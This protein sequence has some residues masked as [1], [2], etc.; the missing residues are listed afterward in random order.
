MTAAANE[1]ETK[2]SL[3]SL[4]NSVLE[5]YSIYDS[6][7]QM[8]QTTFVKVEHLIK[9]PNGAM[10]NDSTELILERTQ[11]SDGFIENRE[12]VRRSS[13]ISYEIDNVEHVLSSTQKLSTKH[14]DQDSFQSNLNDSRTKFNDF[15]T[16]YDLSKLDSDQKFQS[17]EDI[18]QLHQETISSNIKNDDDIPPLLKSYVE[19]SSQDYENFQKEVD[20]EE[21]EILDSESDLNIP[22]ERILEESLESSKTLEQ[23]K[24]E[25]LD[26]SY[27]EITPELRVSQPEV[28]KP[29][30]KT[31]V[32][33]DQPEFVPPLQN[34]RLNFEEGTYE[35]ASLGQKMKIEDSIVSKQ[36][37][38]KLKLDKESYLLS[39]I[40]EPETGLITLPNVPKPLSFKEL[41]ECPFENSDLEIFYPESR[42]TVPIKNVPTTPV[43]STAATTA[44]ATA[45]TTTTT[46]SA[47]LIPGAS[48]QNV[49]SIPESETEIVSLKEKLPEVF[50]LKRVQ[51]I[52]FKSVPIDVSEVRF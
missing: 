15:H 5:R 10:L 17:N 23:N 9:E 49:E 33:E 40:I 41:L 45:T 16:D 13:V 37:D 2:T 29:E 38:F 42:Q 30:E 52:E 19:F 22:Q 25:K 1:F 21:F 31:L 51:D 28:F 39:D 47:T 3:N 24:V 26:E 27:F 43:C 50:D 36:I 11:N 14:L 44:T 7:K 35:N 48:I 8:D 12:T 32:V 6:H 4:E 34:L 18:S 20:D 46:P